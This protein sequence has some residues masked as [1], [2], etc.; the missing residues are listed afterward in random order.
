[1]PRACI[2]RCKAEVVEDQQVDGAE[3]ADNPP[4][5]SLGASNR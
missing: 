2:E 4:V 5:T 1:M 3:S